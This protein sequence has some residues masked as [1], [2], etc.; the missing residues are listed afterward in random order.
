MWGLVFG[1]FGGLVD[2]VFVL[3]TPVCCDWVV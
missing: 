3:Q 2:G 1:G